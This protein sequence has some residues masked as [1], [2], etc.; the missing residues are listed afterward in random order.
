MRGSMNRRSF[1]KS[2]A[3]GVTGFWVANRYARGEEGTSPSDKLNV[4][5]V[6][7]TGR[8]GDNI[9]ELEQEAPGLFNIA[10]L[11][12]VDDRFL[13]SVGPR[14]PKARQYNDYRKMLE[15]KDIDAVLCATADHAH[16]WVTLASLRSGRH[17]YCE[18]PL[19]H[20]VQEVRLVTETA[21]RE[22][23]V[24]QMGTQIHASENYRRVVE[25]IQGGAIGPVSEVHV[26]IEKTWFQDKP[27]RDAF[28][29]PTNL[30]WDLWLGATPDR[31]YSPDY[32]PAV[33]RR[34]WAFGEG[35]LGDMGCHL[36]DLPT[37]AL[38]LTHPT[39]IRAEGPP[40]H[41]EWCPKSLVVHYDF[42]ARG[43]QPPV[44]LSWYDGGARPGILKNLKVDK[45]QFGMLFV[46]E[47]GQLIAD[48]GR[49]RLFPEEKFRDFKPPRRSIA[50]SAGHHKEWLIACMKNQPA[51]TLC[52][53]SYSGPLAET[54]LLGCVAHRAGEELEWD[55][56]KLS[57]PNSSKAE[58]FIKLKYRD[59]WSLT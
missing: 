22:K 21:L 26:F 14:Y 13:A 57:A 49:Y 20:S 27:P 8:G 36:I 34:W 28:P 9:H 42:P 31:A 23:R 19:A 5:I 58:Q 18:K 47:K 3:A 50:P 29:V 24:T 48:Y 16:A 45:W 30:H 51:A 37:W 44:K 6:G 11:C 32:L 55:A 15:Q 12:D 10:A 33:W 1:L 38:G 39:R 35:T 25:L 7:V 53:F 46:G 41:P 56:Q 54:V 2:A 52:N 40:A 4:A 17:V 43:D 59:G